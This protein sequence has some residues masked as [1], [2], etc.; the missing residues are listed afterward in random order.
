LNLEQI[1]DRLLTGTDDD[2]EL[3]GFDDRD[4][5]LDG[6]QGSDQ[7]Q[8]GEGDDTYLFALGGGADSVYD[9]RG[10]DRIEFGELITPEL[11]QIYADD[12]NL[13]FRFQG[14]DDS[15]VVLDGLDSSNERI[16]T[17]AFADGVELGFDDIQQALLDAQSSDG[18]DVVRG[19]DGRD[20]RMLGGAGH[21]QLIGLGGADL[22]EFGIGDGYDIIDDGAYSSG[23]QLLLVDH[24]A[25]DA[26][27]R[28]VSPG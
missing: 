18:D 12:D 22:Y 15:L 28:R 19:F 10:N 5:R 14:F 23:D 20:D 6:G 25:S 24:I 9:S 2:D 13:V 17:Y 21:D 4:D 11:L 3:I 26:S 7:L 1:K 27:V 8:G 16:E